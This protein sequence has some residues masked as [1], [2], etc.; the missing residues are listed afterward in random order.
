MKEGEEGGVAEEEEEEEREKEEGVGEK[1]E[2][3]KEKY[4]GVERRAVRVAPVGDADPKE[5]GTEGWGNND[6]LESWEETCLMTVPEHLREEAMML[7]NGPRLSPTG[8]RSPVRTSPRQIPGRPDTWRPTVEDSYCV[9]WGNG[10]KT[11][12]HTEHRLYSRKYVGSSGSVDDE[13]SVPDLKGDGILT[14]PWLPRSVLTSAA[15]QRCT[16]FVKGSELRESLRLSLTCKSA[17]ALSGR[18]RLSWR[19][20]PCLKRHAEGHLTGDVLVLLF[21]RPQSDDSVPPCSV[22]LLCLLGRLWHDRP[23]VPGL[24]RG[25]RCPS[26]PLGSGC[27]EPVSD[28]DARTLPIEVARTGI[29]AEGRV[30]GKPPALRVVRIGARELHGGQGTDVETLYFT[31]LPSGRTGRGTRQVPMAF[32]RASSRSPLRPS[33]SS[34]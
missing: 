28:S 10:M 18:S 11:H 6:R 4:P 30:V 31:R 23:R 27:T 2:G 19:S 21:E 29:Q 16:G 5:P 14:G 33:V 7:E 8:V 22:T 34:R 20:S 32:Y 25:E 3:R 15:R 9:R 1:G 12:A 24:L 13:G 26:I 17:S